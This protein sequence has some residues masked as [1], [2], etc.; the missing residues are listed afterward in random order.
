MKLRL[1][2]LQVPLGSPWACPGTALLSTSCGGLQTLGGL[3]GIGL[4]INDPKLCI[5]TKEL[6]LV[7]I[8]KGKKITE[9]FHA[10]K[11]REQTSDFFPP[12]AFLLCL[13]SSRSSF[14][15]SLLS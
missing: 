11:S 2:Q 9:E 3:R 1:C 7:P 5:S 14:S 15:P 4:D 6:G 12:T 10:G 8:T 13:L